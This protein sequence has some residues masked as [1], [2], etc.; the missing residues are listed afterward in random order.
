[1]TFCYSSL[2]DNCSILG[3]LMLTGSPEVAE[4]KIL[5]PETV[6]GHNIALIKQM[7]NNPEKR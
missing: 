5:L 4:Q 1:M 3:T 2:Q 6:F 7:V